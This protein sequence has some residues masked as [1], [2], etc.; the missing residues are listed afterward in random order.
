MAHPQVDLRIHTT[1]L[2]ESAVSMTMATAVKLDDRDRAGLTP[3]PLR[4]RAEL[5]DG[6]EAEPVAGQPLPASAATDQTVATEADPSL[7]WTSANTQSSTTT[8][9]PATASTAVATTVDALASDVVSIEVN[10]CRIVVALPGD[11]E[12]DPLG[13]VSP[14]GSVIQN[15]RWMTEC[16]WL[17]VTSQDERPRFPDHQRQDTVEVNG[18]E[19]EIY[20]AGGEDGTEIDAVT[21]VGPISVTVATQQRFPD[22]QS[23]QT[24]TEP[25]R[26]MV[27]TLTIEER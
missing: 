1:P 25:A 20:N 16:C 18:L 23:E 5:R 10:E 26:L 24:P 17:S 14:E 11:A 3:I 15:R 27:G 12:P 4:G 2:N 8:T 13:D 9:Q 22:R 6:A 21:S 19:W 7:P